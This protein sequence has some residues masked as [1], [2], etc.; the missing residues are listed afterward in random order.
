MALIDVVRSLPDLDPEATIYA[1]KPWT[2]ESSAIVAR[3]PASGALPAEAERLGFCYFL[4][5][6]IANE[7]L[8]GWLAGFAEHPSVEETCARLVRYAVSDA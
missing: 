5:V 4:E 2:K 3:E 1:A 8:A 6:A 7:F